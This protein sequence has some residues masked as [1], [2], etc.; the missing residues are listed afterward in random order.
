MAESGPGLKHLTW[1]DLTTWAGTT[2]VTRGRSYKKRVRDL[3]VTKDGAVLAWVDGTESYATKV[4]RDPSG[5]LSAICSCPYPGIPCKHAVALV[6]AYF[7]AVKA[8]EE[9]PRVSPEDRRLKLLHDGASLA[10]SEPYPEDHDEYED[11]DYEDF[12]EPEQRAEDHDPLPIPKAS[13]ARGKK[14]KRAD[15]VRQRLESMSRKQLVEFVTDLI[16][17]YPE[18]GQQIEEEEELKSGRVSGIVSSIRAEIE[19]LAS[20]PAWRS[21]WSDDGNI[22][23]YSRVRER[24]QSL[25]NSGHADEVV[26]LGKDLWIMGNEQVGSSDDEGETGSQIAECMEVVLQAVL[27]SSLTPR[28]QILWIVDAYLSDE[29]DLLHSFDDWLDELEDKAAW[30]EVADTLLSRLEMTPTTAK[31]DDFSA[32]YLRQETMNW[33]IEALERCGRTLEIIPLLKR[34]APITQCYSTLVGYLLAEGLTAEAKAVAV[35]GFRKTLQGAPGIAWALEAELRRMAQADEDVRLVASYRALEFFNRPSLDSYKVLQEAAEAANQWPGVREGVLDFLETGARPD[36]PP[37]K[38]AGKPAP[39]SDKSWPLPETVVTIAPERSKHDRFP[40]TST[41]IRIA[42]HEEDTA[43]VIRWY[44]ASKGQRFFGGYLDNEVAAAV[45]RSHPDVSL[46][47]WR[48]MAE[49][50]IRE[51]KPAAYQVAAIHLVN[52]RDVYEKTQRLNEWTALINNIRAQHKAKRSL[53]QILDTLEA[54][55]IIDT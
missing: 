25:L 4:K 24:L 41:L 14:R 27:K 37:A 31:K 48:N 29:Y 50:Q 28:D 18:I 54:K 42:I 46:E 38:E 13:R 39:K 40:D 45:K 44:E 33:A 21:H 2:I 6:L 32:G 22:P 10:T 5:K 12:E 36:A 47:I 26:D 3:R 34:E 16:E 52:M 19:S 43:T 7:D 17:Q 30:S 55:R 51:V 20:E 23:D 53:M 49:A 8:K 35:D 15:V 9:V 1:E 11:E